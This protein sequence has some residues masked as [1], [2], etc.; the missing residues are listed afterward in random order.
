MV[1][2]I[3]IAKEI[4]DEEVKELT[5]ALLKKYDKK[6]EELPASISGKHHLGE[7][8]KEHIIRVV[9]FVK[10]VVEEFNLSQDEKDVLL[11]SA[12][13]HDIGNCVVVTKERNAE[14]FQKLYKTGWNKSV[15]GS[16]YHPVIGMFLVG[17]EIIEKKLYTNPLVIKVA[18]AI[19]SHMS[20]WSHPECPLPRND[21]EKFLALCD[22]LASKE[23][24]KIEGRSSH[25]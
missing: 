4:K 10:R 14:E 6:L 2:L 23:N 7:F 5:I 21:L 22:Y 8:V 9:W 12:L 15:E 18:L 17:K 3:E 16:K 24:I 11:S 13:L 1:E 19:S 20:H 25:G